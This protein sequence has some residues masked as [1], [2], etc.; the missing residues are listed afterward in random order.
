MSVAFG[1]PIGGALF[2]Y[3]MSKPNTFWR[4]SMIW[5]VFVSCALANFW[6]SLLPAIFSWD[7][8]SQ[9]SSTLKFGS[10][11]NQQDIPTLVLMPASICLGI[12]GGLMGAFFINVNTRMAV[13]R[14]KLLVRKWMKP[15]ET[16]MWCF[17]TASAFYW[18]PFLFNH[19]IPVELEDA[20]TQKEDMDYIGWCGHDDGNG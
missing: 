11:K 9:N 15:I 4:F 5:K 10:V 2:A 6:L 19:C 3:E 1:A 16:F 17:A 7:L 20:A 13:L 14:K 18:V 8:N 12:I